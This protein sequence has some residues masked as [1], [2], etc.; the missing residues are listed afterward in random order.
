MGKT[1]WLFKD[2]DKIRKELKVAIGFGS[3][4]EVTDNTISEDKK[5]KLEYKLLNSEKKWNVNIDSS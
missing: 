3:G 2:G 1:T 5:R 4:Q